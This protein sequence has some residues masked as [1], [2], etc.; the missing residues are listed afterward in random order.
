ME[1]M[2]IAKR[3]AK[4]VI[5]HLLGDGRSYRD[6]SSQHGMR[7]HC[8][9]HPANPQDIGNRLPALLSSLKSHCCIVFVGSQRPT[10]EWLKKKAWPLFMQR[11]K[12]RKALIWLKHNNS[13]YAD[14]VIDESVLNLIESEQIAPLEI[15]LQNNM[16]AASS[17]ES[18]Y[19]AVDVDDVE[20][21]DTQHSRNP[22]S[23]NAL[24]M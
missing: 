20:E 8:I 22:E 21:C 11:E 12:V 24:S 3:R 10:D 9:I 7:G 13:L 4:S 16:E 23:E 5:F 6:A 17:A 18:N 2:L 15:E 14:I 19:A 1:E